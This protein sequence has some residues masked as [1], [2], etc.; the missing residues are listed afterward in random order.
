V[1]SRATRLPEIDLSATA[2]PLGDVVD[3]VKER[4]PAGMLA[5][6]K[7]IRSLVPVAFAPSSAPH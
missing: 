4:R 5:A 2:D 1:S 6:H 7:S 3:R